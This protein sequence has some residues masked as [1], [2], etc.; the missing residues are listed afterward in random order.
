MSTSDILSTIALIVSTAS[1]CWGIFIY[2]DNRRIRLVFFN[3]PNN[4]ESELYKIK[5]VNAGERKVVINEC[6]IITESAID[7]VIF[8][9]TSLPIA[10]EPLD[11][12]TIELDYDR[13][14]VET[15][16]STVLRKGSSITLKITDN[17]N[18]AVFSSEFP[19]F[20]RHVPEVDLS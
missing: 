14:N 12:C 4:N 16:A 7:D 1:F 13:D 10:I 3:V 20:F 8:C 11:E 9:S 15:Y 17:T 6:R 2:R 18:Q 5:I 19:D